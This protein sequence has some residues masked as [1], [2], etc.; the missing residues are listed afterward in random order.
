MALD[1]L[2]EMKADERPFK[3]IRAESDAG[4]FDWR[5]DNGKEGTS[6]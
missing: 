5:L 6:Y 2:L 1:K 3:S 4:S